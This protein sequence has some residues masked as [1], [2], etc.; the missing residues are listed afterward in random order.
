MH[1]FDESFW[2]AICFIVFLLI[3]YKPVRHGIIGTLDK[4]IEEIKQKLITTENIKQEAQALLLKVQSQM[5]SLADLKLAKLA[6]AEKEAQ[7][8]FAYK[9]SELEALITYK[10]KEMLE[11]LASK[12]AES[13][14]HARNDFVNKTVE[15][16]KSYC[17]ASENN[18]VS[19]LAI[20]QALMKLDEN[21]PSAN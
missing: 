5:N 16:V 9:L 6:E 3:A 18:K 1:L 13:I 21:K 15:L 19:D 14:N 4:N 10:K 2:L 11:T 7:A 17:L 8:N 12:Q 20:M